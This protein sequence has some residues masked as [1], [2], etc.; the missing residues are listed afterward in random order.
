MEKILEVYESIDKFS[1]LSM[2]F[3]IGF[4]VSINVVFSKKQTVYHKNIN[5]KVGFSSM[6]IFT[7]TFVLLFLQKIL[8]KNTVTM[9]MLQKGFFLVVILVMLGIYI[10]GLLNVVKNISKVEEVKA[11]VWSILGTIF[12][13]LAVYIMVYDIIKLIKLLI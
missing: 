10:V 7:E 11:K 9:T 8:F 13:F 3:I 5:I 4:V 2:I 12:S 6:L 1:L